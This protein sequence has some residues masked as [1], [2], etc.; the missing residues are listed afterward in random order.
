MAATPRH[1]RQGALVAV[2]G[3]APFADYQSGWWGKEFKEPLH[4]CIPSRRWRKRKEG[5][6][7]SLHH[8][9]VGLDGEGGREGKEDRGA[10]KTSLLVMLSSLQLVDQLVL[11]GLPAS[12][13]TWGS[14]SATSSACWASRQRG[15]TW[16]PCEGA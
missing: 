7:R 12:Q 11:D 6:M 13:A 5:G 14:A 8:T 2:E 16:C 3:K 10:S 15:G 4:G 1:H 9:R